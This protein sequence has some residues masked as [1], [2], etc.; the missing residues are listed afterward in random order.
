M[1]ANVIG[2]PIHPNTLSDHYHK[3]IEV[4]GLPRIRIHDL[5]HGHA[6][7]LMEAGVHAKGSKR[8]PGPR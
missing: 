7:E 5:R 8:A 6:T 2:Q 1:F 4:A 3:I